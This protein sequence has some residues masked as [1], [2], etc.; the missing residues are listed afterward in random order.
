MGACFPVQGLRLTV[1]GL[2]AGKV[3]ALGAGGSAGGVA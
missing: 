3:S 2:V 1:I